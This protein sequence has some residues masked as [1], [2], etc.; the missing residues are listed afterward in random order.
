MSFYGELSKVYEYVFPLNKN[1]LKFISEDLKEGD[2]ILDLACG[3]GDYSIALSKMGFNVDGIDLEK[4]MVEKAICK[5]INEENKVNFV[6]GDMTKINEIFKENKY[7]SIFCVGNSIVHLDDKDKIFRLIKD[8]YSMLEN[9]GELIIQIVNYDRIVKFGVT[10]LPTIQ[11]SEVPLE[12]IRHYMHR[13]ENNKVDFN[14]KL[15][16]KGGKE[17]YEN[18]VPLLILKSGDLL[19]MLSDAGFTDIELYGSFLKEEFTINSFA[20]VVRAKK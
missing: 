1:T 7:N 6:S 8:I 9:D 18:S 20:S 14:T 4:N 11:N 5:N 17:I 2:R 16:L 12:F 10:E 15:V 13:P 19:S 3:S